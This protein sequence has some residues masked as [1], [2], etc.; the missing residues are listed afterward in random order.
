MKTSNYI[1]IGFLTFIVL[2]LVSWHVDSSLHEEEY[3]R[4]REIRNAF[5]FSRTQLEK[6]SNS[7]EKR[8]D[9]VEKAKTY[10]EYSERGY[11]DY[12]R[13]AELLNKNFN[14]YKDTSNLVLAKQ[15][16]DKAYEKKP[17]T[18]D[19]NFIKGSILEKLG[20]NEDAKPYFDVVN[21][22]DSIKGF[23]LEAYKN[24]KGEVMRVRKRMDTTTV[25]KY[26]EYK[27]DKGDIIKVRKPVN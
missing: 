21:K 18:R 22:L 7:I 5:Y 1:L 24:D 12:K 16:A 14:T 10:F 11:Y 9:F 25:F 27:N 2:V 13:A 15:W 23:K 6:D 20:N 3:D 4:K 17:D 8:N 26:E 19:A